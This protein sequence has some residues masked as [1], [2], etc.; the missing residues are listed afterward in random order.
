MSNYSIARFFREPVDPEQ[1]HAEDYYDK[2]KKPMD[3]GTVLQNLHDDKYPTVEK[4]KDDM[5]LIWKNAM[6]YNGQ[7]SPLY[8]IA[9]DLSDIFRQKSE[10]IPATQTEEWLF[11]LRRRHHKIMQLLEARP[12]GATAPAPAKSS[13]APKILLRQK[14]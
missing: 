3:L 10:V 1:D 9:K 2:I 5:N 6:T 8:S 11:A 14:P 4:W 13:A 12:D 7:T